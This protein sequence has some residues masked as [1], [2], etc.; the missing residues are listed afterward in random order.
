MSSS[1][2]GGAADVEAAWRRQLQR[3]E[4]QCA[5]ASADVAAAC[6][7]QLQMKLWWIG[8]CVGQCEVQ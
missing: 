8:G 4:Q 6:R 1:V 5:R 2:Q 3:G 7:R